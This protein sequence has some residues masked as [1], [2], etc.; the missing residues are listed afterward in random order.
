MS[1][2]FLA[3]ALGAASAVLLSSSAW[4]WGSQGHQLVG[5]TADQLLTN[6]AR[7]HVAQALGL[8][9]QLA[10]TWPDCARSV[11][12]GANGAFSYV[13][14]QQE[15]AWCAVFETQS[16][17]DR[18]VDYARRNWDGCTD[19]DPKRACH[20]KYHFADIAIEHDDYKLGYVGAGDHDVVHA[21][22]AAVAELDGKPAPAPFSIKDD[23]E[24]LLMLAH[25][26][27]DLHQPLHVGAVYLD[28]V[29]GAEIDPEATAGTQYKT[30]GGNAII[31][32]GTTNLHSA[33]DTIPK[34]W[35]TDG[36]S[37][38][39]AARNVPSSTG[40]YHAW[41]ELWAT[42]T[43]AASHAALGSLKF[44]GQQAY[45][46]RHRTVMDWPVTDKPA[47]YTHARQQVQKQQLAKA[48]RR[49]ADLLNAI[50]P[51]P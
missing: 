51:D 14:D 16:E 10:A 3:V 49:L 38:I 21:I 48:G 1:R 31:L 5:A 32:S 37:I 2:R 42:D 19:D 39:D 13:V 23:R 8:P 20:A 30:Q 28:P 34:S 18:M 36:S 15:E 43:V 9:L 27:G 4:A 47:N 44:G 11:H 46:I 29:S 7:Q 41:P 17:E 40:D 22:E 25:F 26:V 45:T 12:K 6:N 33:W 24:A 35:G 50:W